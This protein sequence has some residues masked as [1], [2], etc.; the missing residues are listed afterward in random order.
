MAKRSMI[1]RKVTIADII[2]EAF[3]E[4]Q[5]LGEEMREAFDNTPENLQNS[6]VGEARGQ[7]ADDLENLT[8]PDVPESLG[9]KEFTVQEMPLKMNASRSNRR[10]AATGL[11][12]QAISFLNDL[13]LEN[14][15][16]Q[17]RDDLV[18]EIENL[19]EEAQNVEFPGMFG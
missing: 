10:D 1:E 13:E 7:A 14:E 5:G 15:P 12:E 4:L 2:S 6:G 8:E 17:E 11:L 16:A 3:G 9:T 18:G 19:V